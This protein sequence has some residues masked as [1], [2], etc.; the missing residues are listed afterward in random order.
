MQPTAVSVRTG[1]VH[2]LYVTPKKKFTN[3][4]ADIIDLI[5][6]E[7]YMN[8]DYL[9]SITTVQKSPNERHDHNKKVFENLI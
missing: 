8:T 3:I 4:T 7:I 5:N 6:R 1:E 2:R 9:T